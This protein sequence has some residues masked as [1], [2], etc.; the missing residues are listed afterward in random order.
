MHDWWVIQHIETELFV[1]RGPLSEWTDKL[2]EARVWTS[3]E[4]A[5][6]DLRDDEPI[7]RVEELLAHNDFGGRR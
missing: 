5:H 4:M 1:D 7:I 6:R 3:R 2:Q